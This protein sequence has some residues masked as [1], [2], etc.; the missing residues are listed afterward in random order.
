MHPPAFWM[1]C[2][3][4]IEEDVQNRPYA[5]KVKLR[6][7]FCSFNLC[8]MWST[9][10]KEQKLI[11]FADFKWETTLC[12]S[13]TMCSFN[14][15]HYCNVGIDS[16]HFWLS[17][18][19]GCGPSRFVTFLPQIHKHT[20]LHTCVRLHTNARLLG[21]THAHVHTP[22]SFNLFPFAVGDEKAG[23]AMRMDGRRHGQRAKITN[24]ER[25]ETSWRLSVYI[26]HTGINAW[27]VTGDITINQL[28]VPSSSPP[29]AG[30]WQRHASVYA[31]PTFVLILLHSFLLFMSL[32]YVRHRLPVTVE[33]VNPIVSHASNVGLFFIF[34]LALTTS[35]AHC[36][37][38]Y[39]WPG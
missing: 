26:I 4:K 25:E 3:S 30:R 19:C 5:L 21:R 16:L 12:I 27:F 18:V 24:E 35:L 34:P 28:R 17:G 29:I 32:C 20:Y 14:V 6:I 15:L 1:L 13:T 2:C 37:S 8:P 31:V 22:Y 7:T 10:I 36:S 39:S 11:G 9:V 23:R 38:Y 33:T